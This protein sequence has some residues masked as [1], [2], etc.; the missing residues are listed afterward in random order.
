MPADLQQ[1]KVAH[2]GRSVVDSGTRAGYD[3]SDHPVAVMVEMQHSGRN[4]GNAYV[5]IDN[6][7]PHR[8]GRQRPVTEAD[9]A[10]V[11]AITDLCLLECRRAQ[12]PDAGRAGDVN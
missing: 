11:Q 9:A 12:L 4:L 1:R 8:V 10:R 3:V 2:S 7:Q 6:I 5:E